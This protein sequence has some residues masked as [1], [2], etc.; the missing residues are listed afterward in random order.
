[1][2]D[3]WFTRFLGPTPTPAGGSLALLTLAQ[4]AALSAKLM[5]IEKKPHAEMEN[6]AVDFVVF[7]EEDAAL[8]LKALKGTGV[9]R[10]ELLREGE[11]HISKARK[12][13]EKIIAAK[14]SA[15]SFAAPDYDAV[16]I[17]G[18]AAL[19]V[20][21]GNLKVNAGMWGHGPNLDKP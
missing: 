8:Y 6:L 7:A 5:K 1:M 9:E 18:Q 20:L 16:I 11:R 3:D 10:E 4:A 13:L 21:A 17:L 14:N 12:F 19:T 2:N 15:P